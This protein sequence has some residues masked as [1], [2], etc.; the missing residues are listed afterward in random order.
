MR[1]SKAIISDIEAFSPTGDDWRGLD[2]LLD[3]LWGAGVVKEHL[4]ALF[5]VFE[6]F[7]AEDGA[8]V[9][10][11]IVHGIEASPFD[12]GDLLQ[13]SIDRQSSYMGNLMLQRLEKSRAA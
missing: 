10:W 4:I 6:R 13:K 11:G 2:Y 5:G 8:G 3:E 9:L 12:Y 1:T 7:P